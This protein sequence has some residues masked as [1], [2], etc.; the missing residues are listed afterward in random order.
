[1]RKC[2]THRALDRGTVRAR[3]N[4]ARALLFAVSI[5]NS[6]VIFSGMHLEDAVGLFPAMRQWVPW[7]APCIFGSILQFELSAYDSTS[8]TVA[9]GY[10]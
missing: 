10:P 4:N 2:H 3:A 6:N 1:M 7:G 8:P 9:F 5:A